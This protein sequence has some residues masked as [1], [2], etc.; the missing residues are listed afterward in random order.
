MPPLWGRGRSLAVL[1]PRGLRA[2][3]PCHGGTLGGMQGTVWGGWAL[4][5]AP[6]LAEL[7]RGAPCAPP[8]LGQRPCALPNEVLFLAGSLL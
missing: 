8:I 4:L 2:A 3:A 1:G 5:L 6:F 7:W